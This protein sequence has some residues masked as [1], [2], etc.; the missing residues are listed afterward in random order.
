MKKKLIDIKA[1]LTQSEAIILDNLIERYR[2]HKRCWKHLKREL[3][4]KLKAGKAFD[5]TGLSTLKLEQLVNSLEAKKI[6]LRNEI[7][8][9]K[10]ILKQIHDHREEMFKIGVQIKKYALGEVDEVKEQ[11]EN[12]TF[13]HAFVVIENI[14]KGIGVELNK[15]KTKAI[16]ELISLLK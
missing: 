14:A 10:T 15:T 11:M 4:K 2:Y 16:L 7:Q 12:P 13:D 6:A 3:N 9:R 5:T 8:Y 1:T